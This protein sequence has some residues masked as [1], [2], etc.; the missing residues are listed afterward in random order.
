MAKF[1]KVAALREEL[2]ILVAI[3]R[4]IAVMRDLMQTL[5]RFRTLNGQVVAIAYHERASTAP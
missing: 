5:K 1:Q 2:A 3:R 4:T